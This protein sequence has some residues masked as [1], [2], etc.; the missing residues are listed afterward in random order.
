MQEQARSKIF[1][2]WWIT[3]AG[4]I[5]QAT[6]A[7]L[8]NQSFGTYAKVLRDEYDWSKTVFSAAFSFSRVETGILGP[9][10][11]WLIDRYGPRRIMQVGVVVLALGL[12]L[13]SQTTAQWMFIASFAC[14][15]F[16]A[17]LASF[18]PVSVAI[19][20]WFERRRARALTIP[21][22]PGGQ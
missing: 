22:P 7:V 18:M 16:G 2:G 12:M 9:A 11:G 14:M 10:E 20:N 15:A 17:S 5:M 21:V 19:V 3:V 8:V 4:A 13:F 1:Y 6:V